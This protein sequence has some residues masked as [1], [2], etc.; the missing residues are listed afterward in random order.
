MKSLIGQN[1]HR[2]RSR[3]ENIT[4]SYKVIWSLGYHS[5]R[6]YSPG[7]KTRLPPHLQQITVHIKIPVTC[8]SGPSTQP[9]INSPSRPLRT[10]HSTST[11]TLQR[12]P[13]RQ[14]PTVVSRTPGSGPCFSFHQPNTFLHT[15]CNPIYPTPSTW[16]SRH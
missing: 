3:E 5:S 6:I 4:R 2:R 13:A 15:I 7:H 8:G 12:F 11:P 9:T 10:N 14:Q 1:F 16:R